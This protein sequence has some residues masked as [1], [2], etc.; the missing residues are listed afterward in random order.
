MNKAFS[1]FTWENDPSV[2]TP[3]SAENLNRVNKAVNEIDNRVISHDTTK[4]NQVD[5][6]SAITNVTFDES[7]GKFTFIRHNGTMVVLD[8]KLEKLILNWRF[9][10]TTQILYM[11]LEDG[12]EMPVD[13]SAFITNVEFVDSTTIRAVIGTD[14]KVAFE[15]ID[16]S[17]TGNKLEPNY[18]A[19]VQLEAT[20]ASQSATNAQE[21]AENAE[22]SAVRAE[23]A[24]QIA[25][26]VSKVDIAT[27]SKAGIVKPDGTT[28]TVDTDGTIHGVGGGGDVTQED[29][30]NYATNERVDNIQTTSKAVLSQSGWYRIAEYV[31][32]TGLSVAGRSSNSCQITLK[33]RQSSTSGECHCIQLLSVRGNQEFKS[34]FDK[35]YSANYRMFTKIRYAYDSAKAYIEVYC[36]ATALEEYLFEITHGTD[37]H[38]TWKAIT[39]TLTEETADGVT[40]T[41]T[42]DIPANASPA[43]SVDLAKYLPLD[44]GGIVKKASMLPLYVENTTAGVD[45]SLIAFRTSELGNIG[46]IGMFGK[47]NPAWINGS[48]ANAYVLHHDGN[49]AKVVSSAS[50]PSDTKAIWVDTSNKKIKAYINGAWTVV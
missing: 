36:N 10:N 47:D 1:N 9:D 27:T 33:N 24:A 50:A 40:V 12:S 41:T 48:G 42:Y 30:E 5:M 22:A 39:P 32:S 29:L 11:V 21:S 43:T 45:S 34:V 49:S 37:Y 16:G 7:T 8:T 19:D 35:I 44:G 46:S 3:L 38:D 14:G 2:N 6:L 4:A 13:L 28:I 25:Q 18:L 23:E 26:S 20:K 17:I 31:G 15:I